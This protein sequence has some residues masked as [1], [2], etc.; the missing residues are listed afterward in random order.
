LEAQAVS[1]YPARK[2]HESYAE[3][4]KIHAILRRVSRLQAVVRERCARGPVPAENAKSQRR[5]TRSHKGAKR[6]VTKAPLRT[7]EA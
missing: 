7:S 4:S 2:V 1:G 6:E 5:K 3:Q